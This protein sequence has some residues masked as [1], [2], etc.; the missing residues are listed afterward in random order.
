VDLI[1]KI[2]PGERELLADPAPPI[3]DPALRAQPNWQRIAA[4]A[5]AWAEPGGA[6]DHG[7][8]AL[9]VELDFEPARTPGAILRAPRLFV[10]FDRDVQC[11][12]SVDARLD[13]AGSALRHLS[14][15]D[16]PRLVET[17]HRC[18]RHLPRGATLPYLGVFARRGHATAARACVVGVGADMPAY[19]GAVGWPGEVDALAREVL[20]PLART[21]DTSADLVSVLHLDLGPTVGPRIGLEYSFSRPGRPSCLPSEG[22]FLD[23]LVRRGWCAPASRDALRVWPGSSV[24]LLPHD[25]WH[26]RITRRLGHV[27]ITYAPGLPVAAKAYLSLAFDLLPGGGFVGGRP[28]AFGAP[29]RDGAP[30]PGDRAVATS[31]TGSLAGASP[32]PSF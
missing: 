14:G 20:G 13:I 4:F 21:Q 28:V 27:K 23:E 16:Q 2:A 5:R 10:D 9:W 31:E 19:L 30:A 25:V 3:L 26:S 7:A 22:A 12:P 11:D 1:V 15:S 24:E 17:L 6:L 29:R 32:N 18:L 8:R